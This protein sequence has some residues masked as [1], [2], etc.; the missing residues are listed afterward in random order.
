MADDKLSVKINFSAMIKKE[1]FEGR[2]VSISAKNNL[3]DFSVLPKHSNFITLIF[4]ELEIDTGSRKID[5]Q[6]DRGVMKIENN[7]VDIFLGL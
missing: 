2:A 1:P 7:E 4:D 6:F 5:Y 3:G